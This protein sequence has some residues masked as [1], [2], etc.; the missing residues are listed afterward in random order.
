M[1]WGGSWLTTVGYDWNVEN[2]LMWHLMTGHFALVDVV[3]YDRT[4]R[5]G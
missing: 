2:W 3:S 1:F 4:F 5:V